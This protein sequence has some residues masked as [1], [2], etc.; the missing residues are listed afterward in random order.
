MMAVTGETVH[1]SL[2]YGHVNYTICMLNFISN[3]NSKYQSLGIGLP[4]YGGS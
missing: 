4:V 3:K 1:T 2:K